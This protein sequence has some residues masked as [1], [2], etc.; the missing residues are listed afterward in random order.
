M[1]W[2]QA[3]MTQARD[4]YKMFVHLNKLPSAQC[5]QLHYLQMA[6]EKLAK[7]FLCAP[8]NTPPKTTHVALTKF[9]KL[10][11]SQ[12]D[13]R[14]ELGYDK[15]HAAFIAYIDGL[16]PFADLIEN[17]APE[18]KTLDKPNPEYPW[19]EHT[20]EVIAPVDF[21]YQYI[22]ERQLEMGKFNKLISNLIRIGIT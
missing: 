4:D 11:K 12:P 2:Q 7:A 17:L 5:Q 8:N 9:L 10:L 22:L 6:T 19:K 3:F 13:I 20:G 18:G 16:I 15:S 1:T 21:K 14:R